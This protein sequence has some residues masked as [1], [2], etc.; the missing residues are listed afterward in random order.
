MNLSFCGCGFLAV[1]HLGVAKALLQHGSGFLSQIQ[2][3]SGASAGALAAA[4]LVVKP[5]AMEVSC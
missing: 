3:I 5:E 2:K 4:L 1:Y